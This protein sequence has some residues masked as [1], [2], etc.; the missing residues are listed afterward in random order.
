[1][2][3]IC[4]N[5]RPINAKVTEFGHEAN[6]VTYSTWLIAY[7]VWVY[8]RFALSAA[9]VDDLLA[10]R[11]VAVSRKMIRIWV[12]R[13]GARFAGCI[14]QSRPAAVNKWHLN[15]V[16]IPIDGRKYWLWRAADARGVIEDKLR[17]YFKS[18][19]DLA[20]RT[21]QLQGRSVRSL[22]RSSDG[23]GRCGAHVTSC[24]IMLPA[25]LKK[26]GPSI[27]G[28]KHLAD[29]RDGAG[30]GLKTGTL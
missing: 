29:R 14:R 5:A 30:M 4:E 2:V 11:A 19:R 17:S 15:E 28:I 25:S 10:A 16:V 7:A 13:F 9:D 8:R 22:Y 18:V 3:S 27:S 21:A 6:I 26:S 24:P 1:M 12:N 20:P 23:V